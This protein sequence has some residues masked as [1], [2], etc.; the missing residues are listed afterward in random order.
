MLML[1]LMLAV[2]AG[3]ALLGAIASGLGAQQEHRGAADLAA[4]AGAETMRVA[5]PRLFEPAEIDRGVANPRHLER[6][7]YLALARHAAITTARRN[8]ARHIA[9]AFPDA[10]A[11]A[12][13]R[14]AVTITDPMSVAGRKVVGAVRAVAEVAPVSCLR[15][16]GTCRASTAVRSR[17]VRASACARTSRWP[18]IA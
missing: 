1:G 9:V 4:L 3:A 18:S 6:H 17:S 13:T 16:A 15:L 8:G 10:A 12:P 11:L 7:A 2:V 14:I 5:Q